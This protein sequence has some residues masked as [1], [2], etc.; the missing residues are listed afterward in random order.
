MMLGKAFIPAELPLVLSSTTDQSDWLKENRHNMAMNVRG[1]MAD[2]KK[3]GLR[4]D[5]SLEFEM[6]D[7]E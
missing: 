4:R 6:D 7:D 5:L 3:G 1:V 2:V